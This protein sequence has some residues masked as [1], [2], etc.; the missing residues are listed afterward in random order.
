M[1]VEM[2]MH[3]LI[4]TLQDEQSKFDSLMLSREYLYFLFILL[5]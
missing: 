4:D 1:F 3:R 2:L 5:G